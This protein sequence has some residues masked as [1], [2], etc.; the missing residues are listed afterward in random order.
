[1]FQEDVGS[2]LVV[3]NF[4]VGVLSRI[5]D[6]PHAG[7]PVI[8]TKVYRYYIE[9]LKIIGILPQNYYE[10]PEMDYECASGFIQD[11]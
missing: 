2:P 8:F 6:V 10:Y 9:I 7:D 1:M 3:D 5:E 4:I 11:K